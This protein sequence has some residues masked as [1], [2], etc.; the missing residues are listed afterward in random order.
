MRL[1]LATWLVARVVADAYDIHV[2]LYKDSNCFEAQETRM[3]T[4]DNCYANW[5]SNITLGAVAFDL[6]IVSL[7]DPKMLAMSTYTDNCLGSP[8][9]TKLKYAGQCE[10]FSGQYYGIF[11]IHFRSK[12]FH[13]PDCTSILTADQFFYDNLDCGGAPMSMFAFPLARLPPEHASTF[14]RVVT[15][16]MPGYE[17]V[18]MSTT[19]GGFQGSVASSN[20][21]QQTSVATQI[22]MSIG[23]GQGAFFQTP[24]DRNGGGRRRRRTTTC[25]KQCSE[26]LRGSN[27][28]ML[29]FTNSES[30]Q[31]HHFNFNMNHE[32][33]SEENSYE[34]LAYTV[35]HC[36]PGLIYDKNNVEQHYSFMWQGSI[37]VQV[38]SSALLFG[39]I[40]AF[41]WH[42]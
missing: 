26:C 35:G 1:R 32:C 34:W 31:V 27:G 42:A 14:G 16:G 20:A 25:T 30:T 10:Q 19:T 39:P 37:P 33:D 38:M 23:T 29:F 13:E 9:A 7:A 11:S 41:L 24:P 8:I 5:F 4:M 2:E 22:A 21:G 15:V 17:D 3:F 18:G 40:A 36:Y 28:T 12:C 6:T